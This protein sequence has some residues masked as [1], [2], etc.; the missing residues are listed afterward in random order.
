MHTLLRKLLNVQPGEGRKLAILYLLV[1]LIGTSLLWGASISRALFLKRLGVEWLP[2]MFILS[3]LLT[4]PVSILYSALVDRVSNSRLLAWMLGGIAA[5]LVAAWLLLFLAG[6]RVGDGAVPYVVAIYG[7]LFLIERVQGNLLSVHTWTLLND[8]YDIRA[9]KRTFPI[10][11]SAARAAGILG[12]PLVIAVS[13]FPQIQGDDLILAWVVVLGLGVWFTAMVPR[14]LAGDRQ[15][16]RP[17]GGPRATAPRA[18]APAQG[19]W[20]NLTEGFRFVSSSNFLKLL[21]LGAFAMTVVLA[22]IDYQASAV[23]QNS[24]STE[25]DLVIFYSALQ[26]GT[27]LLA[28]PVQMFL[29]S[30]IVSRIGVGQAN[31]IYPLT[32]LASYAALSVAPTI[33]SAVAG[34]FTRDAFRAAVQAPIDNMLYNAVPPKVKGRARAFVRGLLLPLAEIGVGLALLPV[35]QAGI[36]SW[37]L[38]VVGATAAIVQVVTALM[39]RR[40]YTRALVTMIEEDDLSAYRLAGAELGPPDPGTFQRLLARLHGG[41]DED[42]TLFLARIIAEVGDREAVAP[43][44]E[45]AAT[46]SPAVQAGILETLLDVELADASLLPFCR[47]ALESAEPVLRHTALAA[48]ERVLGANNPDLWP[49]AAPLLDDPDLDTRVAA[50]LLLVRCGDFFYVADAVRSLQELLADDAHPACRAAGIGVLKGLGDGRL[51]RNLARYVDDP[52]DL[53]RLRVAQTLEVLADPASPTWVTEQGRDLVTH[54]LADPV[55]GVRLGALRT[56]GKLGGERALDCLITALSDPSDLVQEQA[57]LGLLALG[58]PAAP[59][60]ERFLD[61]APGRDL[62]PASWTKRLAAARILGEMA[63][64]RVVPPGDAA[65]YTRRIHDLY[66]ETLQAIY[67][68]VCL[69]A[70]L[71]ELQPA[72]APVPEPAAA[73]RALPKGLD[74]FLP[75]GGRRQPTGTARGSEDAAAPKGLDLFVA[76]NAVPGGGGQRR[77]GAAAQEGDYAAVRGL[78]CDALRQRNER[79]LAATFQLLA[80]TLPAGTTDVVARTLTDEYARPPARANA[81]EALESFTSPRLALLVSQLTPWSDD[82]LPQLLATSRQ[83]WG[84]EP[85]TPCGALEAVL[86]DGDHWLAATGIFL[87]AEAQALERESIREVWL[88][89]WQANAAPGAGAAHADRIIWEA[90]RHLAKRMDLEIEMTDTLELAAVE[91]LSVVEQAIFLKQVPFFGCMSVDQL[92]TLASIAEEHHYQEGD[93]ILAEGDPGEALYVIVSGRVGIEREPKE[94]RVQRLETLSARQ[95]FGEQTI[96]DGAPHENRAVAVGRCHVLAIRREPLMNLIRRS[97]DLSLTL[98]TV[99]SQRLREADSKLAARTR[100]RPDQVMRLYDRLTED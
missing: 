13:L 90:I 48:A 66:E 12:A 58:E 76:A 7:G 52:D 59:A 15:E 56:L 27:S 93:V 10:L 67:A 69:I 26:I 71:R 18:G 21:A 11:G 45:F 38:I 30:R 57:G 84:L 50:I 97:P 99:L 32:S 22:L 64:D 98:V 9:A 23:F 73:P 86:R 92:R 33:G 5:V 65:R 62:G 14:W 28:L 72:P 87:A 8:Y 35:E 31:L 3:A 81:I 53:V 63:R 44:L 61:A 100:T 40:R 4:F 96:F 16:A 49:L 68:D 95:Y 46:A 43:L 77:A 25:K 2:L 1:F 83:E 91:G 54:A 78:V 75:A 94:G 39:A 41:E 37:P 42:S 85:V 70:A 36:L 60:L 88:P 19:Y 89:W 80:A 51:V 17:A 29:V 82:R 24:F 6:N 34:Q 74:A 47:Q 79:R 55:E 20:H